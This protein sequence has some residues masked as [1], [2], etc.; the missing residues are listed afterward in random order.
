MGHLYDAAPTLRESGQLVK[1]TQTLSGGTG[2]IQVVQLQS[3][4]I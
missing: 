4:N 2:G 3:L 1:V